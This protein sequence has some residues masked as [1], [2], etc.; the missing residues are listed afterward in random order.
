MFE[1]CNQ[2]SDKINNTL[3][4]H[5]EIV[6]LLADHGAKINAKNMWGETPLHIAVKA[7]NFFH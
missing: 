2:K 7:S 5:E 3:A 4:D 6:Q 1:K